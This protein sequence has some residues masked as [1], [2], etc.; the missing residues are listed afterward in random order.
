MIQPE[1]FIGGGE[2]KKMDFQTMKQHNKIK[3][4]IQRKMRFIHSLIIHSILCE[5]R[6]WKMAS[7]FMRLSS[8]R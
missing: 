6:Q 1:Q 8:E 2:T 5:I 3:G 4:I 7:V